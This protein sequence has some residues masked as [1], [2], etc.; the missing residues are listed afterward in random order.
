MLRFLL[1]P[2]FLHPFL[3]FHFRTFAAKQLPFMI[4]S[5]TNL[6][7]RSPNW[8]GDAVMTLPAI[9]QLTASG[10][11]P[12]IL[13]P[14]K[15]TDF[16][17][18]IPGINN[19]LAVQPKTLATAKILREKK[20]TAALL[21]PNSLTT[22]LETFTARIPKRYGF[23][24][25]RRR[26]LLTRSWERPSPAKGYTHQAKHNLIL[27]QHIGLAADN[28]LKFNPIPKPARPTLITKPY[29]ALCPGAEYGPAKRW[30]TE[31]YA[32]T[33]NRIRAKH[34]LE[35]LILGTKNDQRTA[36]RLA[37]QCSKPV[38]DLTGKTTLSEFLTLIAHSRLTLCN[39]SGAMHAAAMFGAPAIAIFGPTE[40]RLTGPIHDSVTIIRE[41]VPCSPCFLRK[42]P[43]DNRCMLAINI[44]QITH[45]CL[46][47]LGTPCANTTK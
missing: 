13:C 30:L 12:G 22:A 20:F 45:A 5:S 23:H 36:A 31:R 7:L 10:I 44:E 24:G 17:K 39:D 26:W 8:L 42:C 6:L 19:I 29:L 43:L 33:V 46:K 9:Q 35:V 21:F 28:E 38:R 16:W 40:P 4:T 32:Q 3:L 18:L 14:E 37:I 15:L 47:K 41:H 25:H 2:P 34:D 11:K 27:L 1:P